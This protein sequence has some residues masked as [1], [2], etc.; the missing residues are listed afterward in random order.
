[1]KKKV[2]FT[3][4]VWEW[5]VNSSKKRILFLLLCKIAVLSTKNKGAPFKKIGEGQD[6]K[7]KIKNKPREK[8]IIS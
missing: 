1:M 8:D 6:K 2:V 3:K 5:N 4:F 7:N